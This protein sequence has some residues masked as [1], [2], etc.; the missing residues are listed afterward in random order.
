MSVRIRSARL[1]DEAG[2]QRNCKTAATVEQVREQV[3]ATMTEQGFRRLAHFVADDDGEIVGNVM[4]YPVGAHLV[5]EQANLTLCPGRARADPPLAG[6]LTD[7]VV[8]SRLWRHGIGTRLTDRV[9]AE[10][11]QWGLVRLNAS[12]ANPAAIAM[13]ERRGF[14]QHGSIPPMPGTPAQWHG[15]TAEVLLHLNLA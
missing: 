13:F 15:G 14:H 5:Q 6:E 7:L 12:S 11:R 4:L 10:A 9:V 1:G 3:R 8:A 2:I